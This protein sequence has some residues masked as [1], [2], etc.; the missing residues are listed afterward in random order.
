[1]VKSI[2]MAKKN[3]YVTITDQFCGAGGSSQ[4]AKKVVD[5]I[6]GEIKLALNHWK[7]AIET[8]NT[9]FPD[10]MHDCTDVSA[11]DPRRYPSTDIL[12][13]S[14]ECTTHSP[15][16]GN[17]HKTLKKQMDMFDS[18]KI[19]PSTERSR[20]TM[21][22][23]C[24]FAEYHNYN[25]IIVEN[26]VEAKTRW[27]LFDV[28]LT[29]MHT[30][31]YQHKCVYF[32]S[33]HHYPTPQSRD[34]MYVVFWKKGNKA[35]LLDHTPEGH[36]HKCGKNVYSI[37]T[38]KKHDVQWGK[39]RQQYV[40]CCPVCSTVIEPYYYASFNCI[41]WSD[42][43]KKIGER[44]R[45][46]KEAT[47]KRIEYGIKKFS[48]NPFL[49]Q[50]AYGGT[51]RGI[52]R[53]VSEPHYTQATTIG[54]GVIQ[55]PFLVQT[56]NQGNDDQRIRSLDKELFTQTT[57]QSVGIAFAPFIV[58]NQHSSGIDFRVKGVN[59]VTPTIQTTHQ[60]SLVS[61]PFLTQLNGKS[62]VKKITDPISAQ[63]TIQKNGL[64]TPESWQSFIA[65]YYG[66][67]NCVSHITEEMGTVTTGDRGGLAV[68]KNDSLEDF[69]YRMLKPMEVKLAMAFDKDYV[70]L[71]NG[72]DQ[73][74]QC[75]NA[76][77]PPAMEFLVER[78]IQSLN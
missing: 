56:V 39:Y 7:L 23:V 59:E 38:W 24:R 15:A 33:M 5:R 75:G 4:G 78:C 64:V 62:L 47:I 10:T 68:Y 48:S 12:I 44:K 70:V 11:A 53:S 65:Q 66:G 29:A 21:W 77:T 25:I 71:G 16:G 49:V 69:Y 28:W 20:A 6:G 67:S 57:A 74:K 9:N 76:V 1:M 14:P 8:H 54:Q 46:L 43:G 19:D 22:D 60:L 45:P 3:S 51:V 52:T 36:C 37:Q 32:N 73:V 42:I 34:R 63:T 13:T 35:P 27:P 72:R 50:I 40:Y 2:K 61:Q 18:G 17:N 41:D 26:V 31:G 58:N 30:L 55:N